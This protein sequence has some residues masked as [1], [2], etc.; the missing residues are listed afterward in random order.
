MGGKASHGSNGEESRKDSMT[1]GR[2]SDGTFVKGEL[3][4]DYS[5]SHATLT[6]DQAQKQLKR[7][8]TSEASMLPA[9]TRRRMRQMA[10]ARMAR[11]SENYFS[12]YIVHADLVP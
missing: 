10:V 3:F 5:P 9:K 6:L 8:V 1:E 4:A 2:N 12:L 11:K 7:Q